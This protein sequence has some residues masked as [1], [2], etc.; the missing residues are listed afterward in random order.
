M[1]VGQIENMGE[2]S[3]KKWNFRYVLLSIVVVCSFITDV[4]M[5]QETE[6]FN[7]FIGEW[8]GKGELF[9]NEAEF[10]MKWEWV[11]EKKFVHLIFQNKMRSSNGADRILKAQA[12]YQITDTEGIQ[13]TW[14]DSRGI[15][16][17]LKANIEGFTM[18][19]LW[20]SLQTEQG[21]TVYLLKDDDNIEVKDLVYTKGNLQQFGHALYH[22]IK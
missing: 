20:G 8:H 4:A 11:L 21:Q 17:P 15:V 12:F 1:I 5:A 6:L 18:T 7:K 3:Y 13:G 2:I 9:G 10:T 19:T 16:L 14:F 22:R